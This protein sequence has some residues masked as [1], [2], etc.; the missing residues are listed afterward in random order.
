M[1]DLIREQ[2]LGFSEDFL[3]R[4]VYSI[5][6]NGFEAAVESLKN[7]LV[8][9]FPDESEKLD[10]EC[11]CSVLAESFRRHYGKR[12]F[13]KYLG[14]CRGNGIFEV[15]SNVPVYSEDMLEETFAAQQDELEVDE[16]RHKTMAT[17]YLNCH[18]KA[19]VEKAAVE[20]E[21]RKALLKQVKEAGSKLEILKKAQELEKILRN[22]AE[23]L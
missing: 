15:P 4:E 21:R 11:S 23:T 9:E 7:S 16:L 3:K 5:G 18:L 1:E 6:F 8:E 12:W 19:R 17:L 2:F 10:I 13:E 22:K 14:Y 20:L